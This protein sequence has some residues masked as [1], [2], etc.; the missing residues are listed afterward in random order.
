M[1]DH[2]P[3]EY[4]E[5]SETDQSR[6][7]I[8][9]LANV[10]RLENRAAAQRL[11]VIADLFE[12]RRHQRGE[13]EDWAVDTW[14]AVGAE[15]AAALRLSL[16]KANSHMNYALAMLRLPA[17]AAVFEAGDIDCRL[18][19]TIVYRT[20]LI[21]DSD[22]MAE[23]DAELSAIV[24][25]WPS[26]TRGKLAT[27]IDDIVVR[28]DPDAVRRVQDRSSDCDV[29][30]WESSEGHVEM[31]ARLTVT[32]GAALGKRLNAM[33]K[34]VCPDDP[35]TV[36]QRRSAALGALGSGVE[37]V[38]CKCGQSD[39]PATETPTGSVV[40]HVV[41]DQATLDGAASK[42]AY[43]LDT[44]A[45]I[46]P[47]L[48]AEL[49]ATA[50]QRP[51]IVP[52]EE[53][54]GSGYH[55]S[56]ALA[57]YVRSRDLTCRAPGCDKPATH[58]DIDHTV[59]WPYGETDASNLKCLCRDHHILKTF[60]GWK[61]KQLADGT[62]I[63]TLPDGETYVTTPGSVLLFPALMTPTGPPATPPPA[64]HRCGD[65]SAM[66]PRRSTTRRQNRAHRI[67]N[68]RA[69]NRAERAPA[70]A[71]PAPPGP[72]ADAPPF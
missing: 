53:P 36:G 51:V 52:V 30:F 72:D 32:D 25:R 29:T 66:M 21:T 24:A 14:A 48:L 15:V 35:R 5:P 27:E 41:A 12:L 42:P 38:A 46:S 39:C 70:A 11:R 44:G 34:S 17:V 40:I 7:L 4:F 71:G 3:G 50:R 63:W 65:R 23:V 13:R 57:D 43:L 59:P 9:R 67:A 56:R 49:K 16:S 26:M 6:D 58:C 1:F 18:F 22:A 47:E 61:D 62:V 28:H 45:L 37:R 55:P 68:E 2:W 64:V 10:S 69:R 20:H 54:P 19:K 33:A 60:W 31:T 8:N